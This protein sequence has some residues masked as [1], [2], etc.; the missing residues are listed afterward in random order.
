MSSS[1]SQLLQT[2][3]ILQNTVFSVHLTLLFSIEMLDISY[4]NKNIYVKEKYDLNTS[5]YQK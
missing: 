5:Y 1:V 2:L 3:G 4:I